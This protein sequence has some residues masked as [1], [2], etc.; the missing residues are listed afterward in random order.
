MKKSIA[1]KIA[2][3]AI[4]TISILTCSFAA[5]AST[6]ST[7]SSFAGIEFDEQIEFEPYILNLKGDGASYWIESDI[8]RSFLTVALAVDLMSEKIVASPMF[9][10]NPSYVGI[11]KDK[12]TLLIVFTEDDENEMLMIE[13][14]PS[15]GIANCLRKKVDNDDLSISESLVSSYDSFY[16]NDI[17]TIKTCLQVIQEESAKK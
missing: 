8:T 3:F 13:Y 9:I 11:L 14:N 10:A 5:F 12:L 6:R 1:C 17:E 4:I 2:I 15:T 7:N 16:E